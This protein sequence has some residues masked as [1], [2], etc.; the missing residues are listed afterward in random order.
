MKLKRSSGLLL[1][2]SSLPGRHG[3][4]TMGK[5]A[6]RFID[7][8]AEGGQKYWQILPTGPVS[9]VFGYSPYASLSSFAGNYLF[10]N[11]EMLQK[12]DFLEKSQQ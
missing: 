8:L 10:I 3:I 9:S 7:Q 11:L 4:G 1:H 5:E 12:E 6:Y 2:I